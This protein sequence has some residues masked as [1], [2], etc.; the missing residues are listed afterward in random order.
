MKEGQPSFFR[1]FIIQLR[2][3]GFTDPPHQQRTFR[4]PPITGDFLKD[5][6]TGEPRFVPNGVSLIKQG[7]W[8]GVSEF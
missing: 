7:M 5:P 2:E 3:H 1:Q 4:F 6:G 8:V